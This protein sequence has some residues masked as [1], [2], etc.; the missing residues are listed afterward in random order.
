M[1]STTGTSPDQA[2]ENLQ[3][4]KI[5][6]PESFSVEKITTDLL[7]ENEKKNKASHFHTYVL[8]PVRRRIIIPIRKIIEDY[9]LRDYLTMFSIA[10][11]SVGSLVWL[12]LKIFR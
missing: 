8:H 2:N 7:P 9:T 10:F 11:A 6:P 5:T 4:K 3:E 1:T 12:G